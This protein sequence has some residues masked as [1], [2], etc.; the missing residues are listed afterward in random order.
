MKLEFKRLKFQSL[1]GGDEITIPFSI[2]S[3][4]GENIGYT[5][6]EITIRRPTDKKSV[7]V[8][9]SGEY[10]KTVRAVKVTRETTREE[11]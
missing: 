8:A 3:G 11:K 9:I 10:K 7:E 2:L 5:F 6:G 1:E 4:K